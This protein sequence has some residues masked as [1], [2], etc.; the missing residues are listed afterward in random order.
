MYDIII[1]IIPNY[2]IKI[3]HRRQDN[4]NNEKI[5]YICSL[6]EPDSKVRKR[7]N[8]IMESILN[9]IAKEVGYNVERADLLTGESII[10]DII[11]MIRYADIV[12]AD[13]TDCNP[14]V[15]YEL[16]IRMAIKG[17]CFSIIKEEYVKSLPFDISHLRAIPY[18][19]D[20]FSSTDDFRKRVRERIK[21]LI[22]K[23]FKPL[24]H[25]SSGERSLPPSLVAIRA[26][27]LPP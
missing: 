7:A 26:R 15:L 5:A 20:S 27:A 6:S 3:I 2:S 1:Y 13:L 24:V 25:L 14:N 17:R 23:P 22:N 9:P 8:D 19:L 21:S 10:D 18:K 11:D 12:V 4:Y 16:G